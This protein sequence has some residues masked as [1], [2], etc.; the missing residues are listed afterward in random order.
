MDRFTARLNGLL[1]DHRSGSSAIAATFCRVC[2]A[3]LRRSDSPRSAAA[4]QKALASL[5]EVFPTMALLLTLE[6]RL[7]QAGRGQR[8]SVPETTRDRYSASLTTFLE[9]LDENRRQAALHF[10]RIASKH[11]SFLTLSASGA[12]LEA[13]QAL[14]DHAPATGVR[15]AKP[16]VVICES[17]PMREGVAFARL[18]SDRG[19]S[20]TLIT[21][22]AIGRWIEE[23]DAVILGADW[24]DH[25]GFINK[26]G[27]LALS[28]LSW[29]HRKSVFVIGDSL[30]IRRGVFPV[31]RLP[32]ADSHE[33]LSKPTPG[34]IVRNSYFEY[35][36][37][38][39]AH[40]L[41]TEKGRRRP[42]QFFML[43]RAPRSFGRWLNSGRSLAAREPFPGEPGRTRTHST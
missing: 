29:L 40:V 11:R 20:V 21:D 31:S 19:C 8:R 2:L 6:D 18:L 41:I 37:W 3:E 1:R 16:S 4:I 25:R 42:A 15:A 33:M 12:V 43:G 23:V 9:E 34:L 26:T 28:K 32:E 10:A 5:V 7:R 30:R 13:C 38:N 24:I 14:I 22:G 35:I 39:R 17:R 36:P 27:S